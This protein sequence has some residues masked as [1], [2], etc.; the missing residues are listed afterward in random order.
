MAI[1]FARSARRHRVSRER[2]LY[3]IEHCGQPFERPAPVSDQRRD[4][5]WLYVGDDSDSVPLEVLAV[6][7]ETG[8]LYVIHAMPLRAR[9]RHFYEEALNWRK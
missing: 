6:T 5:R 2:V 8:D 9:F 1:R 3:V 7:L 4:T